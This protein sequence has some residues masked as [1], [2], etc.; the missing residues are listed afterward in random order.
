LGTPHFASPEQLEERELDVRSDIY[1]LG[2]TL[3]YMLAGR[4]P[5]SGSLAQVMSQHLHREPPLEVLSGQPPQVLDLL[6]HM[7]AKDAAAR[8]Q[9]P[10]DLRREVEACLAAVKSAPAAAPAGLVEAEN[11]ETQALDEPPPTAAVELS[12]GAVLAGRYRILQ[13]VHPS[14]FGRVFRAELVE[15]SAPVALVALDASLLS[16]AE[17]YTRIEDQVGMLQ[18]FK[19][20]ALRKVLSLERL[21]QVSFLTLEWINGPS[22]L[23]LM[24]SRKAL[25]PGEALAILR[26]LAAG[27]DALQAA[28]VPCPDLSTHEVLVPGADVLRPVP[29]DVAVKFN[30]LSLDASCPSPE[31]TRVASAFA[32][33]RESGAFSGKEPRAFVYALASLAYELLG[34]IRSGTSSGAPVPIAGLTEA[35]NSALRRALNPSSASFSACAVFLDVMEGKALAPE[36][37]DEEEFPEE[38]FASLPPSIVVPPAIS[39]PGTAP[40][41]LPLFRRPVAWIAAGAGVLVLGMAVV[42]LKPHPPVAPLVAASTPAPQAT[43]AST[44]SPVPTPIPTPTPDPVTADLNRILNSPDTDPAVKLAALLALE[45]EHFDKP[46]VHKEVVGWLEKFRDKFQL[47]PVGKREATQGSLESAAS[48]GKSSAAIILGFLTLKTDPTS[49]YKWYLAAAEKGDPYAMVKA[50]QALMGGQGVPFQDPVAAA[51]WYQRAADKQDPNAMFL[52]GEYYLRGNGVAKD[53]ARAVEFLN[54]AAAKNNPYAMKLLG[55]CYTNGLSDVIKAD[56]NEAVRLYTEAKDLGHPDAQGSLGALYFRAEGVENS[57]EKAVEIFK[58]GA[59]QDNAFCM[60]LYARVN[61]DGDGGLQPN[62]EEAKRWY[63]RAARAGNIPAIEWCKKHE[64]SWTP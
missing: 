5:F 62:L 18:R 58:N 43:S 59:E 63:V 52:L 22:L 44:A 6:R 3:Y 16:S 21:G 36:I 40:T 27:F 7:L 46:E 49:S 14:D 57:K 10:L 51:N 1:S 35:A 64:P 2:V 25:P 4:A 20:P 11:F 50:G 42:L 28:G 13:E 47:M 32:M 54:K 56:F 61:E 8:P 24:R 45:R 17:A 9:T 55:D 34:G 31:V 39:Q 23:D 30:P 26:P 15:T 60:F 37:Q 53:D 12:P 48:E 29:A 19:S 41:P 38:D 33:A